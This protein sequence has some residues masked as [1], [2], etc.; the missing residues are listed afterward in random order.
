MVLRTFLSEHETAAESLILSAIIKHRYS[1]N[2]GYF[3]RHLPMSS[4]EV[5]IFSEPEVQGQ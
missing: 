1:E 2:V 4:F 3:E 5:E